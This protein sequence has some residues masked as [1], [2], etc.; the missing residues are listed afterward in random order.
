[1]KENARCGICGTEQYGAAQRVFPIV[2]VATGKTIWRCSEHLNIPA[3][4]GEEE[5]YREE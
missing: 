3:R 1:M 5:P 4:E 2:T